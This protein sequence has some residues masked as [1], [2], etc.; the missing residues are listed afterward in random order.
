M[1][2]P[3]TAYAVRLGAFYASIFAVVGIML[4][5]WPVW[6][7][8]RGLDASEI[9][10][11]L[12]VGIGAKVV[13]NPLVA[14]LADRFGER[15]RPMIGLTMAAALAFALFHVAEGFWPLLAVNML[16]HLLW[17]PLMPLGESLTMLAVREG[18]LDYGR[19]RLWGSLAFILAA[20]GAGQVLV[21]HSQEAVFFLLLAT[22]AVGAL[23][24]WPLPDLRPE[25]PAAAPPAS[26]GLLRNRR[27]VLFLLAA[28]LI[29]GSHAVY[30][31]FGTLHWQ[32]LGFGNDLIG[33]LWAEGVI[34]EVVLFALGAR[35]LAR[36]GPL[37][38][39]ALGGAAAAVRWALTAEA[40]SLPVLLVAQS[41]H[42]FTF[43]ASHLGAVHFIARTVP[44]QRSATAMAAYGA[45]V[46][47]LGLGSALYLSGWLFEAAGGRAYLVMAVAGAVGAVV[48]AV[49]LRSEPEGE[50]TADDT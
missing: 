36:I 9:G 29:Q 50:Q 42:A 3:R 37:R 20:F 16:F 11:L 13:G 47:G 39:L 8:G 40:T 1:H 30:Y 28:T 5:F 15:R 34:A 44:P 17:S 31:A 38:L 41:L 6:L 22:L 4:P 23:A 46:M 33:G 35:L 14:H 12:A 7:A 18:W 10:L 26:T 21:A 45:V 2:A 27:F 25:R 48:A 24:A 49:L 19:V 32:G 43:A